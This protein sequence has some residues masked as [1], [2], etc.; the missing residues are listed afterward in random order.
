MSTIDKKIVHDAYARQIARNQSDQGGHAVHPVLTDPCFFIHEELPSTN[1]FLVNYSGEITARFATHGEETELPCF[2]V[3]AR[4]SAGVGRRGTAWL[5]GADCITFSML[6]SLPMKPAGLSG[7]SLVTG[8]A[9]AETLQPICT[10]PLEL[11]WPNDVLVAG[12]KLSGILTEV[13]HFDKHG[14]SIV[15]GVGINF[16]PDQRH[17]S[18]DRPIITIEELVRT[19]SQAVESAKANLRDNLRDILIG[20]LAANVYTAHQLFVQTGWAGF[21]QRFAERDALEGKLVS[22]QQGDAIVSGIARGVAADGSLQVE[23]EGS[24][25]TFSAGEVTLGDQAAK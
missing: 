23:I 2:C 19:D 20:R 13:P 12:R 25:H 11:K 15:T 4:Q 1:R 24:I 22:M 14:T 8:V 7:L 3:A 17:R 9:I 18:I 21:K 10:K 16:A 6:E 5:S